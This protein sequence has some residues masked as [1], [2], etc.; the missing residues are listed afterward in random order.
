[1][2]NKYPEEVTL[3][4][5]LKGIFTKWWVC[6]EFLKLLL[7]VACLFGMY[8]ALRFVAINAEDIWVGIKELWPLRE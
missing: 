8:Y 1:M 6:K 3:W 7:I 4:W 5:T 2:E